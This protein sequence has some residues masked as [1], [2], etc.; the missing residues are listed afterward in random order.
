MPIMK[1]MSAA[2]EPFPLPNILHKSE[3][4]GIAAINGS[5]KVSTANPPKKLPSGIVKN[6]NVFLAEY[7]RPCISQGTFV[8]IIT[9]RFAL[10]IGMS[11]HPSTAPVHHRSG[12]CPNAR[13]KF[14]V[15]IEN[16]RERHIT[17]LLL[18]GFG[19]SVAIMLPI[20][21]ATPTQV[22]TAPSASVPPPFRDSTIAGRTASYIDATRFIADRYMI[23]MS[24][25]L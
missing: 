8:R 6:C 23:S 1:N 18:L 25:C 17:L 20:S 9:S 24:T 15:L 14:S 4:R 10:I 19:M 11:I 22:L 21:V 13:K 2:P 16:S 12:V 7:T 3:L 5:A